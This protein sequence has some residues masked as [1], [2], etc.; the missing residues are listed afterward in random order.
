MKNNF[1]KSELFFLYLTVSWKMS[2]KTFYSFKFFSNLL[3]EW[4]LNLID[5][6]V[7]GWWSWKKSKF[8]NYFK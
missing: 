5:E 7:K 3:K 1:L 8:I 6:K 2:W 4:G